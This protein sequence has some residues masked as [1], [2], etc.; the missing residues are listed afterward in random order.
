MKNFRQVLSSKIGLYTVGIALIVLLVVSE[1][2]FNQ[3]EPKITRQ[4]GSSSDNVQTYWTRKMHLW[5]NI[6]DWKSNTIYAVDAEMDK[7]MAIDSLTGATVWEIHL[8]TYQSGISYLLMGDQAVFTVTHSYVNAYRTSTGE[9]LWYSKLGDGHVSIYAQEEDSLLR[10]YYGEKIF[11]VSQASGK[12]LSV[13]PKDDIVWI[14]NNVEV[15]CPLLPEAGTAESCYIGLT[16]IDRVTGKTLW[17]NNKAHYS[18]YYQEQ[19][20]HKMVLVGFS[21]DGICALNAETGG[22]NWCL[23]EGKISNIAV[24]NDRETGYFIRHDFSLVKINLPTGSILAETKF[25]PT[26][27]P[28]GMERDSYAYRVSLTKDIVIVSFGDSEQ[29]FGLRFNP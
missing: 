19:P 23:P 22:Y 25:L 6:A 15:H 3:L 26:S 11:E 10:I 9:M 20:T 4:I 29:T 24:D 27:L 17:E 13:Q 8:T 21:E 5:N 1:W 28:S 7:L 2:I 16:G 12:I 18:E 14:Q